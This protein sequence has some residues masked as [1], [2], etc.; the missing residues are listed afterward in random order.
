MKAYGMRYRQNQKGAYTR[1]CAGFPGIIDKARVPGSRCKA[2]PFRSIPCAV[3][4][5]QSV[6]MGGM[7]WYP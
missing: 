4:V 3:I 7:R 5:I 2:L 1:F 6:F